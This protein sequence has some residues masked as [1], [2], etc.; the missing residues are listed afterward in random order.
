MPEDGGGA[1]G[2]VHPGLRLAADGSACFLRP[3]TFRTGLQSLE[4]TT[5]EALVDQA[6]A[7][8]PDTTATRGNI[9]VPLTLA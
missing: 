4:R 5:S 2:G 8:C 6:H 7:V 1:G 9:D 3:L